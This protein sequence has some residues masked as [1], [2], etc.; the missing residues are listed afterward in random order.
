MTVGPYSPR[1]IG[2]SRIVPAVPTCHLQSS[3]VFCSPRQLLVGPASH[4]QGPPVIESPGKL[5]H[6]RHLQS[7]QSVPGCRPDGR[8]DT[9]PSLVP[10]Q[11][12][13][14]VTSGPEEGRTGRLGTLKSVFGWMAL[15]GVEDVN[16]LSW[17]VPFLR[18]LNI[19][20]VAF[21]VY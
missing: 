2:N 21:F 19:L 7:R 12:L 13:P 20:H 8:Q 11:V 15:Y 4:L 1:R 18:P 5:R 16:D 17:P 3:P 9:R 6:L 14:S 10:S